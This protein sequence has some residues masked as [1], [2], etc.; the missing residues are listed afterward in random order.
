METNLVSIKG[1]MDKENVVCMYTVEQYSPI[2][3]KKEIQPFV[4]KWME[5]ESIMLS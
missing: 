1:W 4:T 5:L 3:K 2:K